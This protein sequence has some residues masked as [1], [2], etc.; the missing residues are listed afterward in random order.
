MD[1][2]KQITRIA[3][4]GL[5]LKQEQILLCRLSA[6]V[7]TYQGMWTLPG[8]GL[9]FGEHPAQAMVREVQEETGLNV[10]PG[11]V[12]GIDTFLRQRAAEQFHSIRIVYEARLQGGQLRFE[13]SGTTDMCAWH[14]L[15]EIG[16]LKLVGL[17]E[18]ALAMPAADA[19][20]Q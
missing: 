15:A 17:V 1:N 3:A 10:S 8:G 18:A 4:Y 5:V 7:P 12:L 14:P 19:S 16:D 9:D 6:E 11:R 20:D 13:A 2:K